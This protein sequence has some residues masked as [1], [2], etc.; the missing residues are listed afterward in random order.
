[1]VLAVNLGESADVVRG[2]MDGNGLFFTVL[3]DSTK[4]V[5]MQ[6]N[7]RYI[8][9]TYFIDKNGIIQNVKVGA[10]ARKYDIDQYINS[11]VAND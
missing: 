3:L 2:F 5:G 9:T 8:P 7:T 4:E 1:M 10:F 6:Y 11:L